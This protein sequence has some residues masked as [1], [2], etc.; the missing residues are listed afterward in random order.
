MPI[1][2]VRLAALQSWAPIKWCLRHNTR[3]CLTTPLCNRLP[4]RS[5][6]WEL[7]KVEAGA[8]HLFC[9]GSISLLLSIHFE[10]TSALSSLVSRLE[11]R[12]ATF[13][14]VT[15]HALLG[16]GTPL[17]FFRSTCQAA[18][19]ARLCPKRGRQR[20]TLRSRL[21]LV[22]C[23]IRV[24]SGVLCTEKQLQTASLQNSH[25]KAPAPAIRVPW[26]I[27]QLIAIKA[28]SNHTA[29]K[30]LGT[31]ARL[32]PARGPPLLET[33]VAPRA[34]LGRSPSD[35]S[36]PPPLLVPSPPDA[37]PPSLLPRP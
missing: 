12:D 26:C 13:V 16:F 24:E 6:N 17:E 22:G 20:D 19:P 14:A 35:P 36:N 4:D 8:W 7:L 5:W 1:V 10:Q 15:P 34:E 33:G 32:G 9:A 23:P 18:I 28:S 21:E 30:R 27:Q 29:P 25:S 11:N 3:L 31:L 37:P 2:Q